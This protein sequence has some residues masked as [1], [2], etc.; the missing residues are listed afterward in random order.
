[1][2]NRCRAEDW[3][4]PIGKNCFNE[5]EPISNE[6]YWGSGTDRDMMHTA[7]AAIE[8]L[9]RRGLTVQYL[10][11]TQ[12][13]DYRKD[14]HPSIYRKHWQPPTKDELA[15]PTSY[16]DCVHWCLPGVPDVWNELLYAYYFLNYS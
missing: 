6:R 16:A 14:G 1:M 5:T 10:K 11:I 4:M 3:G 8:E 12:L 2:M 9:E 15:N 13:S 7:E